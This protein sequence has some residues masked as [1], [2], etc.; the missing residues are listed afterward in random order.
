[1][2]MSRSMVE[3]RLA[4]TVL[5]G[6]EFTQKADDALLL[7]LSQNA[8]QWGRILLDMWAIMH[9]PTTSTISTSNVPQPQST[10]KA[11]PVNGAA[12]S[13]GAVTS[14]GVASTA[15]AADG[16]SSNGKNKP[17]PQVLAAQVIAAPHPLG[18]VVPAPSTTIEETLVTP[19]NATAALPV[20]PT[21]NVAP[22]SNGT[23]ALEVFDP[24]HDSMT[25]R[26]D[27]SPEEVRAFVVNLLAEKTGY[28]AE[29]FEDHLDLETDLGID[30]IKQVELLAKV[31]E[32]YQLPLEENFQLRD[33]N[34]VA[35]ISGY[36]SS[37]L[38][39]VQLV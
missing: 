10:A 20:I 18:N 25:S 29:V 9:H 35:A 11:T 32:F 36:I 37:R 1:M 38:R 7:S 5:F 31:R 16:T 15:I 14:N 26:P 24:Q 27:H 4:A 34:T 12:T 13:N 3:I 33:Y 30:S 22:A 2:V 6:E 17:A 8:Q 23:A 19:T 21:A 28:P 39:S